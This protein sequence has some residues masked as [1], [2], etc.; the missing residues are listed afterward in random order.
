M[1][2][3]LTGLACPMPVIRLKKLFAENKG[4]HIDW[5]VLLSDRGAIKDLPAFC[6]Q[7]GLDC[8]LLADADVL[9]FKVSGDLTSF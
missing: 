7:K 4:Q 2:I 8:E 3:D 5:T 1:N 6:R 9:Q